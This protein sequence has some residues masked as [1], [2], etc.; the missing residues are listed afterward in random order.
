[1]VCCVIKISVYQ[2]D[3][4]SVQVSRC[5]KLQGCARSSC[6]S[7]LFDSV[8][9]RRDDP[10]LISEQP[11]DAMAATKIPDPTPELGA[12]WLARFRSGEESAFEALFRA[13]TPGLIALVRRYV[14]SRSVAEDIVQELFFAIWQ[15]RATLEV[16]QGISPYLYR[17]ARNRAFAYLRHERVIERHAA[18]VQELSDDPLLFGEA[19]LLAML[20]VK[21]AIDCLP[22]KCQAVF[23]LSRYEGVANAEIARRLNISTKSVEAHLTRALRILRTLVDR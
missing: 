9:S 14:Y 12:E 23:R 16:T 18:S 10:L 21:H 7:C 2:S 15:R 17:A 3:D 11:T 19:D 22:T 6:T 1:V 4:L 5:P 8:R 13:F 20:D